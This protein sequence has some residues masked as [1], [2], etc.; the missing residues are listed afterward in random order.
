MKTV[1]LFAGCGGLSLGFQNQG[2]EIIEAYDNWEKAIKVYEKN[3]NH[4]IINLDL[5]SENAKEIVKSKKAE[6]IIGGSPCQDFSSAGKQEEKG[7]A[8]L[9]LKFAKIIEYS[10]PEW[11]VMENVE[12][13]T[14]SGILKE[15]KN[16]F[17]KNGYG[18]TEKVLKASFF[19]VPQSRK[20]FFLIG[21]K[22]SED[23]FL[24]DFIE[25]QKEEKETSIF[26][27][28]GNEL[29]LEYYYRHPR[30]YARRG[31]FSIYEPSPTIRGVNRPVPKGYLKH[32]GDPVDVFSSL[33]PL[34]TKERSLIQTF[35][36]DFIFEGTKT[37]LEQIIGNAVPVKLAE[38][39]AKA[40]NN[41]NNNSKLKNERK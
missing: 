4:K 24:N 22:N 27:Y 2:F 14:K 1:D 32:N 11:F 23:N 25:V 3:F 10:S 17:K 41:Y 20:R 16:I 33:R 35:P 21:H 12:R 29:G 8:D 15:A 19:G 40:I 26:D 37:D 7:R 6:I 28:L 18:L 34:T 39:I 13:I 31:I 38:V 9:T 5:S 36:K 30:S